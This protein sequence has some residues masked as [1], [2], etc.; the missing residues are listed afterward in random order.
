MRTEDVS[1]ADAMAFADFTEEQKRIAYAG[2]A[3]HDQLDAAHEE[4]R[5]VGWREGNAAAVEEMTKAAGGRVLTDRMVLDEIAAIRDEHA[6]LLAFIAPA[7]TRHGMARGI[8]LRLG[9]LLRWTTEKIEG[10]GD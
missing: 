1:L 3:L 7:D 4:G 9:A 6:A 2:V 8:G 5:Q 10:G